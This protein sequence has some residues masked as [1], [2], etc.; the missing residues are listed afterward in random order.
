MSFLRTWLRPGIGP[1]NFLTL[2]YGSFVS[3]ALIV[4]VNIGQP[5]VLLENLQI[6]QLR[7]RSS[8]ATW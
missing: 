3:I 8:P 1:A 4:F 6:R 5:Y 2:L 7:G